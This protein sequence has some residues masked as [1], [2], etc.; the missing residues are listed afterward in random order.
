MMQR[1]GVPAGAVLD[2]KDLVADPELRKRGLFASIEHPIRGTLVIPA[3]PV[4]M[5]RSHVPVQCAPLLGAD[6]AEVLSDWL[7]LDEQE[8]KEYRPA[9]PERGVSIGP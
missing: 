1:A 7:G 6:T 2:T 8:I 5:S 9:A 3:F 4:S